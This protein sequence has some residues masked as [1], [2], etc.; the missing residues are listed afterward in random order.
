M[1]GDFHRSRGRLEGQ[2]GVVTD[3]KGLIEFP[4]E[5]VVEGGEGLSR[6][7]GV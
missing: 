6:G 2:P 5:Q 3:G 1:D 4:G 7:V